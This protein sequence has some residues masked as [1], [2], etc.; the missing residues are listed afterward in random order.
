MQ[1]IQTPAEFDA[2]WSQ[3][4]AKNRLRD[5]ERAASRSRGIK[6]GVLAVLAMLLLFRTEASDYDL[7]VRALVVIGS[8][9]AAKRAYEMGQFVWAGVFALVVVLWNPLA[10]AFAV[11]GSLG[12]AAALATIAVFITSVA[13]RQ[14]LPAPSK[15]G[16]R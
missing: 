14:A 15:A 7:A 11:E 5:A 9:F 3:W 10:P 1:H 13:Q 12:L 6:L 8:L 16:V 2:R 4:Q